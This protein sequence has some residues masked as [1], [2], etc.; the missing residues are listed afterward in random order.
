ML[1]N[2]AQRCLELFDEEG[3]AFVGDDEGRSERY[4]IAVWP[5][6]QENKTAIAHIV[7]EF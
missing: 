1:T 5:A 4:D 6:W 7:D 2:L 3:E